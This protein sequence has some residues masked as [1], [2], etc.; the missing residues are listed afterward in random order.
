ML[1]ETNSLSGCG[2]LTAFDSWSVDQS[3]NI[4][5]RCFKTQFIPEVFSKI[6]KNQSEIIK[7]KRGI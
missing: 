2:N 1:V 3:I 6:I 5:N 7:G 4:G